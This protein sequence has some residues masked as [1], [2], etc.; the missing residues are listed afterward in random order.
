MRGYNFSI[1]ELRKH[2]RDI[3]PE[4]EFKIDEVDDG[5]KVKVNKI[6]Y[7]VIALPIIGSYYH[8]HIDSYTNEEHIEFLKDDIFTTGVFS[9]ADDIEIFRS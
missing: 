7:T 1:F 3:F 9:D 4:D 5:K 6:S 8:K 2:Y